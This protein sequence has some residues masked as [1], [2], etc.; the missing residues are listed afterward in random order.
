M[1]GWKVIEQGRVETYSVFSGFDFRAVFSWKTE[2]LA[3]AGAQ[4]LGKEPLA[5]GPDRVRLCPAEGEI[6]LQRQ[7]NTNK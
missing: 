4:L 7:K 6:Q 1:K 3:P 5:L 2:S